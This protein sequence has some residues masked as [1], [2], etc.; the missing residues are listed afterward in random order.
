MK[1]LII[2]PFLFF[3]VSVFG[4]FTKNQLYSGINTE[5]RLKSPSQM[6]LSAILDSLNK[7][8]VSLVGSYANP[9]W[10]T[11]LAWSKITSTPTTLAGYGIVDAAPAFTSQAGNLF[12]ASPNGSSGLPLF[13]SIVVTDV[14]TLNQN[15]T[16]S[17]ATLTTGRTI[18]IT[19]DLSYTSPSFNGSG[20]VTAAGTLATV[21]SNV[22]SFGSATQVGTFTVNGKGLIT[23]AGN[24]TITPAI[25][26]VTGLGTGVGTALGVNVGTAGSFVVNGGALGTPSSG[27]LTN[28]TGLPLTTGITGLLPYSNG[29]TGLSSLGSPLQFL[30]V[31][32]GGTALEYVTGGG[33]GGISSSS[34]VNEIMKSDG[35]NA[36]PSGFFNPST[37]TYRF[38]TTGSATNNVITM[39]NS[40]LGSLNIRGQ[41]DTGIRGGDVYLEGGVS[42]LTNTQ[43]GDVWISGGAGN[44]TGIKGSVS[45]SGSSVL[46][47]GASEKISF[48]AATPVVKQSAATDLQSF[49]DKMVSYGL[50]PAATL[51]GTY[52][53]PSSIA[54]NATDADFTAVVN[55]V[56]HLPAATLTANRTIT[57]PTGANGDVIELHNNEATYSWLLAGAT[58]YLAD[59]TTVVTSLLYNVPTLMQKIDGL[60]II[61]N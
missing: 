37:G 59:R 60:W 45:L 33:G 41:S 44:G 34:G 5:I 21:N 14:P 24:T 7:S 51:S 32:A 29:G 27:V 18:G 40:V 39:S 42:L 43:G 19:G 35:T 12:F 38:G 31:N 58:V 25:G 10:I 55:S 1:K 61:K 52:Y 56:K 46:L 9:T 16:G 22:G 6:R 47:A 8:T 3:Y 28:A 23:A 49:Y 57:I 48:F 15:T 17:A 13:R 30:R 2:I 50:L 20:N 53:A 54:A 11:S 4:Q 36:V 26:S